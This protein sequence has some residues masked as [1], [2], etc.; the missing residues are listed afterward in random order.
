M[1]NV[2]RLVTRIPELTSIEWHAY[3]GWVAAQPVQIL[4]Y[5]AP[6]EYHRLARNLGAKTVTSYVVPTEEVFIK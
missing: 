6:T 5:F 1:S 4:L 3:Q 2:R